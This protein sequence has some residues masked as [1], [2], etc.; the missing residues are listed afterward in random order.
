MSPFRLRLPPTLDSVTALQE[1]L[2]SWSEEAGLPMPVAMRLALVA[3][4]VA[5]NVAN[6][7]TG[8]SYFEFGA[9]LQAEGV[10]LSLTDDGPDYDPLAH[11]APD[12]AA[13]LEERDPGGLGIH[14]VRTMTR[15]AVYAREGGLNRLTCTL[16]LGG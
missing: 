3:E 12:T 5:A 9:T 2:D 6:H 8:A 10:R 14:L 15:D 7:A 16:P 1:A 4:E 11:T 13:P